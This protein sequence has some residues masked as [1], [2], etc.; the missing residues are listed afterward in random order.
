MSAAPRRRGVTVVELML[1]LGIASVFM[2]VAWDAV[3]TLRRQEAAGT[4]RSQRALLDAQVLELAQ[5]DLR[6][7][8]GPPEALPGGSGY[9]IT[10]SVLT[11]DGGLQ[12]VTVLWLQ[13]KDD[14]GRT[15]RLVRQVEGQAPQRFEYSEVLDD[16]EALAF[17][18]EVSEEADL[19]AKWL[20]DEDDE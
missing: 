8:E 10:R 5:R 11:A 7:A 12:R 13:E 1:A 20:T 2:V 19:Q 4:E 14:Q 3:G 15:R 9:A 16:S 17:K 6:A 18:F